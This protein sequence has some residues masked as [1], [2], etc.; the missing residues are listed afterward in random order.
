MSIEALKPP[1]TAMLDAVPLDTRVVFHNVAQD[2][3]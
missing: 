2:A 3:Y 1:P